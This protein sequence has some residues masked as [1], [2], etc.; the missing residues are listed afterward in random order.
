M[1]LENVPDVVARSWRR[2]LGNAVPSD[3]EPRYLH[4]FDPESLL[5]RAALPVLDRWEQQL[6]D[7]GTTLFLSDRGGQIIA[8]RSSDRTE[9]NRLDKVNAAEGFDYSEDGIGTNALGT[10][11]AERSP[12]FIKGAEHYSDILQVNACAASPVT[13]PS[14]LIIGSIALGSSHDSASPLMLS[15]AREV[16]Q[17]IERRL[18]SATRPQDLAVAL[19]FMRYGNSNRPTVVMDQ[20]TVL[21]NNPGLPYVTVEIHVMLWELFRAHNWDS[22]PDFSQELEG[23]SLRVTARRIAEGPNTHYI[24]Y[25]ADTGSL[26]SP[27]RPIAQH[28]FSTARAKQNQHSEGVVVNAGPPGSG[29][30]TALKAHFNRH[31]RPPHSV[32]VAA[33]HPVNWGEVGRALESGQDVIVRRAE[34]LGPDQARKLALISFDHMQQWKIGVRRSLLG[35]TVHLDLATKP[36]VDV[37]N[38]I[39]I[40][41]RIR[42]LNATPERIPLLVKSILDAIDTKPLHTF[43]PAALQSMTQWDWPGNISELA[44]VVNYA[45]EVATASVI[46][47]RHLPQHIQAAPP[48]KKM[49]MIESAEREAIIQALET[50]EG[51]KSDAAKLLGIGRTTIYRRMRQLRIYTDER[52]I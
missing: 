35:I 17:Q 42:P 40:S 33:G 28:E 36:L 52:S 50:A 23:A 9:L 44:G 16:G 25:F 19:S 3:R 5:C 29:R 26:A 38:D 43:S 21:A 48:R 10:S 31:D 13:A 2:S 20:E 32:V 8:R 49:T 15:M 47:R 27:R 4:D 7:T 18:C 11:L 39:G 45:I 30:A 12:I 37:L 6:V 24:A 14:G 41:E 34:A 22:H 1:E 46:E 51:N